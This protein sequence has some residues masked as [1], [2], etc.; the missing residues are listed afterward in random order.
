LSNAVL[1][2]AKLRKVYIVI[3][4]AI[5]GFAVFRKKETF[6]TRGFPDILKIYFEFTIYCLKYIFE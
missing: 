4:G 5:S 2:S 3:Q 1:N 6:P